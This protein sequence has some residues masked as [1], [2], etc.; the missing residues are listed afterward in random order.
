MQSAKLQKS[1]GN[2]IDN[3]ARGWYFDFTRNVKRFTKKEFTTI[4]VK[5]ESAMNKL[6]AAP[7]AA[8][9]RAAAVYGDA[10][11]HRKPLK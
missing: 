2:S 3:P 10:V 11:V 1:G 4:G 7:K 8:E 5:E 9:P 6:R